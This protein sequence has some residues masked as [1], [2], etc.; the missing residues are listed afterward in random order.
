MEEISNK[1]IMIQGDCLDVLGDTHTRTL[2]PDNSID[3]VLT[4]PPY[5][6]SYSSRRSKNKN[7]KFGTQ[8]DNDTSTDGDMIIDSLNNLYRLMKDNTAL[9]CFCNTNKI[10]F[11]KQ[12]IENA[13]FK[14]KN[15][16]IWVKNNHTAGDLQAALGH[17]YE[18]AIVANKGRRKL[19]GKR[20]DDIIY[21]N[22]VSSSKAQHQNQK[23]V[24]ML[25]WFLEKYSNEN[26]IVLDPFAGSGS[27]GV[28]CV[29]L[30]RK[31]I[32]IELD[33]NYFN[34]AKDR[35]KQAQEE[36]SK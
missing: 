27:T 28:A 8:I 9:V 10:D 11:F 12:V 17:K 13:G 3:F 23:P 19:N 32:G 33:E 4:D 35:I 36:T 1:Q 5:L 16:V 34:V 7:Y 21:F 20:E 31:F 14:I 26:D 29:N 25:E 30:N 15:I 6:Q 2:I 18:F 22:K 24:D